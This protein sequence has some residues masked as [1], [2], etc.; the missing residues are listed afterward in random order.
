MADL[1]ATTNDVTNGDAYTLT[2]G[3][4]LRVDEGIRLSASEAGGGIL[5][6]ADGLANNITVKGTVLGATSGI[7]SR[8]GGST[9]TIR[10]PE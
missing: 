2:S 5:T 8:N 9:L 7:T 3:N 10:R 1:V 6:A 4:N